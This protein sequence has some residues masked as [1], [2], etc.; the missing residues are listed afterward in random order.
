MKTRYIILA[1]IALAISACVKNTEP[2]E[3]EGLQMTLTAYQEGSEMTRTAVQDGG[4]QVYWEPSDEIKVFFKGSSG[5]FISQNSENVA[6]TD[7]SGT[8][9]LLVGANEGASSSNLIWGLYPYR[10]DATFDGE[11]VTTTLPSN[12]TG[13]AGS[14]A[15]NTHI[16]MAQS[17]GLDLAFYNVCGGLR[18]SLTQEG[19]KRITFEGNNGESIAGKIKVAFADGIPAVQEV[20]EGEKKIALSAPNGGSFQTGQWYYIE[21]IPGTLSGGY[22]MVFYKESV[23]AKVVSSSAVT[24][25][26][27]IFGS[28]ADIDE[29]VSFK[30]SGSEEDPNPNDYILFADPIA[31]YACV[32]KFDTNKDGE[33]SYA[34]AASATSLDQLFKD[35]DT[36]TSF[37]EIRFFTGVTSTE[38]VFEYYNNIERIT[39][40]ENI[41]KVGHFQGCRA[42]KSIVFSDNITSL[43]QECF[44]NCFTVEHIV[45]PADLRTIPSRFIPNILSLTSVIVPNNLQ[46]IENDA[47]SGCSNLSTFVFPD[48]LKTIG[49]KAFRRCS[50]LKGLVFPSSLRSIGQY[51]FQECS[52]LTEVNIPSYASV[53]LYAFSECTALQ[54]LS[55]GNYAILDAV[56]FRS[57]TS[58]KDLTLSPNVTLRSQ[59][60]MSCNSLV[61]LVLPEGITIGQ[62][63]F[64]ACS[65]IERI[66]FPDNMPTIPFAFQGCTSLYSIRWPANVTKIAASAF[67]YAKFI[68]PHDEQTTFNSTI[69]LPDTIT[70]IGIYALDGVWNVVA[71]SLNPISVQWLS[72]RNTAN[73]YVP[74]NML[75]MYKLRSGWNSYSKT[76]KAVENYSAKAEYHQPEIIDLGLPSGTKWA[77]FNLG[78]TQPNESGYYYA[79]GEIN[80]NKIEYTWEN[81]R[82]CN[83]T[84]TTLTKYNF[85][86]ENGYV[87][88]LNLLEKGDD[89][90]YINL[91]ANWYIPNKKDWEELCDSNYCSWEWIDNENS[92]G[93]LV[94]SKIDGYSDKSIFLPVCG[95]FN[96]DSVYMGSTIGGSGMY[97]SSESISILSFDSSSIQF[98]SGNR[99]SGYIIRPVYR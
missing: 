33:V 8:I 17:G 55:V 13:R 2:S 36:V 51:A 98:R 26:R 1:V 16:T 44:L 24:I 79:W 94:T 84:S 74:A 58:L 65:G 7:F 22:R 12:Q 18:F 80:P 31:K 4:P 61:D 96:G 66:I 41:T 89:A 25:K 52:S 82:W 77:S 53:G 11:S 87:D 90:A 5:R 75:E 47:F 73:L 19:I 46:T 68:N 85:D 69:I 76:I 72:F 95:N 37:D 42:L 93:Y 15:K 35:W 71:P 34:E 81:Y 63:A 43:P 97:W 57:C 50:S 10:S 48:G 27:G 3:P 45:L 54:K 83:G 91:G 30:E 14:F 9:N 59:V 67:R 32:E 62:G 28:L 99:C 64:D 23:S 6:V 29:G 21:A 39:L 49:D 70:E 38:G 60:F 92:Q 20:S 78:A 56:S 86:P 88:E 40:P